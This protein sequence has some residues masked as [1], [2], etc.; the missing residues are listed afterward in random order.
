MFSVLSSKIF[1]GVTA[2]LLLALI[3]LKITTGIQIAT[4]DKML[5]Q[6][7]V[8][9]GKLE[10]NNATLKGNV[11]T[12]QAGL[13]QCNTSAKNAAELASKIAA[14][15]AAAVE[16]VRAAGVTATASAVRRLEVL[17]RDGATPAEQCA[18]AN[19][20]FLQGAQ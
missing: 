18:Q 5:E 14:S 3:A 12:L 8:K 19:D 10:A 20:I 15:G 7:S 13:N 6:Q 2:A 4:R 11:T 9:I 16:R 1:A 17:P